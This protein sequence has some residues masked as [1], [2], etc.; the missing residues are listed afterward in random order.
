MGP[1][2]LCYQRYISCVCYLH[3]S[4]TT[5][6]EFMETVETDIDKQVDRDQNTDGK[7][8]EHNLDHL[9]EQW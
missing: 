6:I 2:C 4:P 5:D 9:C 7:V 1:C 8:R 3:C